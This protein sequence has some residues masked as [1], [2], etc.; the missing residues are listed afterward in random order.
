MSK[1]HYGRVIPDESADPSSG[2][3]D[4]CPSSKKSDC[5]PNKPC[6]K[7]CD[8]PGVIVC[9]PVDERSG[10]DDSEPEG[11]CPD[12]SFLDEDIPRI[13]R[14]T[15][16]LCKKRKSDKS[17]KS[18]VSLVPSEEDSSK[19]SKESE[20]SSSKDEDSKLDSVSDGKSETSKAESEVDNGEK[21]LSSRSSSSSS[22]NKKFIVT[23]GPKENHPW[24]CYNNGDTSIYINGLNGPV[25][26]LYRGRNYF[27]CVEQPNAADDCANSPHCFILTDSPAGGPDSKPIKGGF[28]PISKGCVTFKVDQCTPR[29]FFYQ[30]YKNAFAG[31][32]VVVHDDDK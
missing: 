29:Y 27:F 26:H 10:F 22:R 5:P 11:I 16:D 20:K 17:E 1:Y 25:I 14:K 6:E 12:L 24:A 19:E 32:L 8:N 23:F 13:C 2:D 18:D 15:H 30:D 28:S 4:D 9:P 31:G 7:P 21:E 3:C